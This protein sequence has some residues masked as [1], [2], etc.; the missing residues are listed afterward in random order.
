MAME[1]PSE[2][3]KL[4]RGSTRARY[5]REAILA[6]LD[7]ALFCNV[8]VDVGGHPAIIPTAFAILGDQLY[9]HGSTANRIFRA[10]RDGSECCVSVTLLDALVLARSAF[11]HS[12]NY[13]SVVIYG[14]AR[15][16]DDEV[17]KRAAF[18]ALIEH[19]MPGRSAEVRAPNREEYLRTLVLAI[20]V[21][22]ASAKVRTGPPVEEEADYA[23]DVWAG[24][25]P[26]R[27]VAEA[28]VADPQTKREVPAYVLAR[29]EGL[30]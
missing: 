30:S 7:E 15:E 10:M 13:R 25:L 23:L 20:P 24:E 8:A 22:E 4:K 26:L 27:V 29:Y 19:V 17:E 11:H 1:A 5:E 18:D 3:T 21:D 9:V 6:I 16:V 2:R 28:P 14:R 12:V